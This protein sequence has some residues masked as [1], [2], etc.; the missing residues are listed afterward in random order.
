MIGNTNP[1]EIWKKNY[2]TPI[3]NKVAQQGKSNGLG[4]HTLS[5]LKTIFSFGHVTA[6]VRYISSHLFQTCFFATSNKIDKSIE[7]LNSG[8]K[9][10]DGQAVDW[11][12]IPR[13]DYKVLLAIEGIEIE[14][15]NQM[16][17]YYHKI[18]KSSKNCLDSRVALL[19]DI[20]ERLQRIVMKKK[21]A[22]EKSTILLLDRAVRGKAN[23][24]K[25]LQQISSDEAITLYHNGCEKIVRSFF[26][27]IP[28]RNNRT[29]SLKMKE[30]WGEFW[31]E[32]I[33]PCHRRL[34][35]YYQFWLDSKPDSKNYQSF[36]LWLESQLIPKNI[37]VV[38]YYSDIEL[39][40]CHIEFVEGSLINSV[41]KRPINTDEAKR[42]LFV[43]NLD[44]ELYVV[45]WKEGTWHTS[46][47]R[48]KPVLGAGLLH[49][50]QGIIKMVAFESGHYLPSLEQGFQSLQILREKN[51]RFYESV[52]IVYFENR[53]KYKVLL[54]VDSM[55]NF[56]KF[57]EEIHDIS[58]R[59]LLS[60]NEF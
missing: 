39:E 5:T 28:L 51:A 52:E 17:E 25:Q 50:E 7:R 60:S 59:E 44:Q 11:I 49:I 15:L 12:D 21:L 56:P 45:T 22:N 48:G 40:K 35:N 54:T 30:F 13:G 57:Y 47:S 19:N 37:P 6:L 14:Y 43:I 41:T 58:K 33:D 10:T 24:L 9:I 1:N 4:C 38:D 31:L 32:S 36:F 27:V 2:L 42:N 34:A 29:Y 8:F 18:D 23:Y 46:L 53:N 16:I 26:Q 3:D 20:S 55:E